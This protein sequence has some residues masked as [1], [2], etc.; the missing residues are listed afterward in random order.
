[1]SLCSIE[2][3]WG[4]DFGKGSI[5]SRN[6]YETYTE[7]NNKNDTLKVPQLGGYNN[8]SNEN[9]S[10]HNESDNLLNIIKTLQSENNEL[11]QHLQSQLGGLSSLGGLGGINLSLTDLTTSIFIGYF[12]LFVIDTFIELS[13]YK[14]K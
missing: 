6:I 4:P 8:Y 12:L 1:M 5:S 13:Q 14:I 2:E 11:K 3:A 10:I 9:E 7:N